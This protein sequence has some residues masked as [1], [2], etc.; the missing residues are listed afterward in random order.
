MYIFDRPNI[1]YF[2]VIW[3][4][5]LNCKLV[6]KKIIDCYKNILYGP[7]LAR[8]LLLLHTHILR[9]VPSV[10]RNFSRRV[11]MQ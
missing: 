6:V 1:Y 4:K 5:N 8:L 2:C 7:M 11:E 3:G 9:V 10:A